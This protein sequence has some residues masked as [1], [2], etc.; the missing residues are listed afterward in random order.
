[1]W[2]E[3]IVFIVL[4]GMLIAMFYEVWTPSL[5]MITALMIVWNCSIITTEDALSGFSNEGMITVGCLFVVVQGV[6]K[7]HIFERIAGK[8]YGQDT[9][10]PVAL[11]RLMLLSFAFSAFFNNLF[12]N[13]YQI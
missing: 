7:S 13:G 6:E 9:S 5:V 4:I 8:I 11:F 10:K 1:M 12:N 2:R 3:I